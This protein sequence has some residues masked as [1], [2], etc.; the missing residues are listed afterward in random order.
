KAKISDLSVGKYKLV[1]TKSLPGYKKLT[2]P[3]SFEITKGMTTVLSLKVENEQL[4]KGSVEITKVDKDSKKALKGV[5]FEVQ[6]EAGTVVKEVKTDKDGK[7]KISDLLVGKYKLVEK[8]SLPGY[9]KLTDPVLFEIKKGMTKVLSLKIENEMVDTGNV[10]I[11]K[12]DKDNKAPLAGVTFIVQDEKGNEVTK[13]TTD[14]DG[15]ANVSDL[16]V[17][18]YELVEVESLPGYKKLEKP[19][20]FEIK[21]GMTEVLSLKVENEMVDTGNVEI[22]KIDKDSK[23]PLENVVFEVRDLKGKVVAKVTTDKEGKANVSDLPIG[24]YELV[25][26]ETPAGYKPLEKPIS[27][28]IE[29]GRVTALKLT[30]EN[31]LV[32]TGNVE[33]TKV[34][35]ENKDALADAV[36][37]IQDEAGQVVAKITTDKKGQAQVT[38]LSVGTYK[39]VEVKAPKGYKQL[40][41]PITF[42]IEKGMTKSL[43]L[44]VENEMLDKGNVEVTKVDKDSQK[45]LEGVVFEV[46]DEQGKVVTEV[47]T[48]K[49]GK[50]NVSDLSV[51]K[52]KLV[53]TKS[54]PG[55]KKLTEP[56]SFEIKKGMTKVL[57]LKVENELLDKGSVAI[58]K[59]D[60][61]SG[62]VLA[63]VTFEVQDEKDKVV[64]KVTTDK[65]GKANVSDLSVGKYKL[66]E[67]E[68]LP[69]YKKLAKPVSF[70]IKKGMTEVLS[71]KVENEQL[72][73][74]SVE[75]TKVDKD[76]QKALEG[77]TFEVQDEKGKV[78]TKV[79]TDK[80]GK[81][82]ISDLSVGSYKLVEV[83]SLP[84]YK[85]LTEP[86]S[87]EIK[88]GMTEV[89]SLKVENEQLDKGSVEITK[90]DKDSQKVLEGV[91]FE[92]QD[93]Q[94]K[95][96]TEVKTDKNGKAK[97]SDLSVGKYKLVEKESLPGYKQLTEPV[98]FEIKKGMTEVLSLKIEN[99]MVDTGNVEITKID[100]DNKAPLAGVVFEVQDDKGKVVTKVTTDKAGKATVSDLSVGKYK[101]VEV[102]SLPGYKKLEKPVPFEIKKGMTKSLTFTVEN[103]MVDTGNVEI[104]KIDKDS[105][106]PLENVVFEVRDSKGKVVA[107][108][109]TD[110]EG[111]ANV[112]DLSIG[113]YEL[114]EVETPAGYKPLEKPVS[115]EIEKGRVTALQL[116]VEN[117]LV[118]TGNIEIT[119]VDKENKD[120]L[121]D[122]V[123][124]IQD[125]AGQVVAKIT[126]DKKGQAQ[127]TNLS[128]GTY[129][130]VEVKA[131]K[132]YKQL[133][134]PITF[135]I[136]KGMTKSLALTVENEMLDKGNV[137]V[138]KVDKDSQ[139]VLEGVVFEVQD[140]KGKVVT[141]VTTDKEGKA[142]VSDLSVGKYKLVETKSLPG[143]KKL[144]E[145]VSFEIK[146]GMTKVLSLKV[147]NEKLDKG[148]VEITKMAAESKE[149]LSGA[150]F[151]V[152][153]DKGKVV[154]KV[155]TD[156]DGKA[157]IADLSVGNYTLVEVEAPKGYEKLTNPIPFEITNGMINAVQLE[158]LNKLNHLAPPGPETPDPEKPGTPDPEKPGT[159]DPEKPGTPDPEKP[160]TPDP[161]KPG[162]PDP[163][164]PGTPNPEK[165][166]KELPKTG[167]KMPVEPYMGALLVMMS[168][169]LLVLGR[170]QQR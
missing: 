54:L 85:K 91:V 56:V 11:T 32:D 52:Y 39:L 160:G 72:D 38:N 61:E 50:A 30:V 46:Q 35:K 166:E 67:V 45:V 57:S 152:H 33:I 83:E 6:D 145:P 15:K 29:K 81:A 75:I 99:E 158:V 59:V 124:E 144:T 97:I 53:E 109:T 159:P 68:S 44:T 79:T 153:D 154:V 168:F 21:K 113:K 149:V 162:T 60:K 156:K 69:G 26:V 163:E 76:S 23:A 58:T 16:P 63:G 164:K 8:E 148:S 13:V 128:V 18:K 88:K 84:G 48:D 12:I 121:A 130:L 126:T 17:G 119:K 22:T 51:G 34:D 20:S 108:V 141:E 110:K 125:A 150:V 27:F 169:G 138:T 133:V 102:E 2:E 49:E 89:L 117:E 25:E 80:E 123:F 137:E 37:E 43:A 167:Q 65:E 10:E 98:S 129:K 127:V 47:T 82:K 116:T 86:V 105:K 142:N 115:F 40:V 140:D 151:E 143:Y 104:T 19:V 122:A 71:L 70:E 131:P 139:K 132:G 3:V 4:D 14:K 106:A 36:F 74:G 66:V 95:V 100:K 157:K 1:E 73:K 120:A 42:Q 107:K 134:D 28:E 112:S 136:E 90:V 103:E 7:A 92:V 5:V 24:K 31:E 9:K 111:K 155:T 161:E 87:F 96:V 62:A 94:G 101:L 165:P 77:V 41:D 146:K 147:E 118:D 64:T 135:Q 170:K 55:Y 93:E 114:V 78:V